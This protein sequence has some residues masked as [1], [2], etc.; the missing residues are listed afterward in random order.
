[1]NNL[2][3]VFKKLIQ[4]FLSLFLAFV[5]VIACPYAIH[6]IRNK[7]ITPR[8]FVANFNENKEKFET[9][10]NY[11]MKQG[12]NYSLYRGDYTEK[13]H[14][15]NVKSALEFIF[16]Q[17]DCNKVV[18]CENDDISFEYE[19]EGRWHTIITYK[20]KLDS[21]QNYSE[22]GD[23]WYYYGF[24]YDLSP[25]EMRE[26]TVNKLIF[27]GVTIILYLILGKTPPFRKQTKWIDIETKTGSSG[28]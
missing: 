9:V 22:L 27:F 28:E 15:E 23:N 3:E 10:K 8:D 7:S 25:N 5:L 21:I 6:E 4:V 1:M 14:D 20:E 2:E 13:V 19:P 24:E 17:Q 11:M 18:R 12:Q 16:T 26:R